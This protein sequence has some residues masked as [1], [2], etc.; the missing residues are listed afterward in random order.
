MSVLN[1]VSFW[2]R[3]S[4][5]GVLSRWCQ[6]LLVNG[7]DKFPL[8]NSMSDK[9]ELPRSGRALQVSVL[10]SS[11]NPPTLA[12]HALARSK[13][14]KSSFSR[15]TALAQNAN[16]DND[17]RVPSV[18]SDYDARL[19]L[20]SVRNADKALKSGDATFTQ[21]LEMMTLLALNLERNPTPPSS[22][23]TTSTGSTRTA[24]NDDGLPGNIAVAII[25]EPTFVRK[26]SVLRE[27]LKKRVAS[28]FHAPGEF[29]SIPADDILMTSG[30][31]TPEVSLSFI[32]GFDTL[33]RF[34]APR[35]YGGTLESM[36]I[37][38]NA[39]FS[40]P[41][42]GNGSKVVCAWRG[43]NKSEFLEQGIDSSKETDPDEQKIWETLQLAKPFVESGFVS[44][45]DLTDW[46]MQLSSSEVRSKRA[47]LTQEWRRMVPLRI[48]EYID[49]HK[50]YLQ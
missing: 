12:H 43:S 25:D 38:L 48:D 21:R 31:D 32:M 20:L 23:N 2:Q 41:P 22:E 44:F 16:Q 40:P 6:I 42:I 34:L 46:E 3:R 35:Y 47:C 7:T 5:M 50:L 18:S 29:D 27:Y 14:P 26:S 8:P 15:G 9:S 17:L 10:D 39:F 33:E 28:L 37:A 13:M 45:T 49:E 19:L 11:F 30:E 4:C 1:Q 36:H 24:C